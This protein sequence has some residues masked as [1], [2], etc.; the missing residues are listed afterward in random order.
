[1]KRIILTT[2]LAL[3]VSACSISPK[4]LTTGSVKSFADD[5]LAR[6]TAQQEPIT[7]GITIHEA[8]ARALKYNLDFHVEIFNESLAARKLETARLDTLPKL[9]TSAL[10][11][12][13]DNNSGNKN[14]ILF[15]DREKFQED[16]SLSWNILDFGLS[17]VRAQQAAD[18]V[19]VA[20]ENRR[21]IINRVIED[22][23]TAY[24]R[25]VSADRLVKGLRALEGRA[26][27]ALKNSE[28]LQL[29]GEASPLTALTYQRELVE[30][31]QRIQ[32]LQKDLSLAK[33]QLAALMNI[34]P[35]EHFQLAAP[36]SGVH[37][38]SLDM[39]GE[40]MVFA[41]LE[42]RPEIRDIQYKLRINAK[43]SKR[44]LLE[45]L[46]GVNLFASA[47]WDSDSYLYNSNWVGWGARATWNVMQV[48]KYPAQKRLI[49]AEEEVLDARALA[50][51]MAIITQVH[52]SRVRYGHS[53]KL[54][55]TARKH[56]KV[57]KGIL[58][59]IRISNDEGQASEQ[60]LIREEMNTLASQVAADIA[61]A[62]LQNAYANIFASMGLDPYPGKFD[63]NQSVDS[64]ASSL[65][66][67]WI[68]RGDKSGITSAMA[69]AKR[70]RAQQGHVHAV[71]NKTSTYNKDPFVKET[72]DWGDLRTGSVTRKKGNFLRDVMGLGK[73]NTSKT[74]QI[75]N[76]DR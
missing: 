52:V 18:Q 65:K 25:A 51:T 17:Y 16:I 45:L 61:Y 41:A 11:S 69:S 35:G 76:N 3:T 27:R 13:R 28:K 1:M 9:A 75:I 53:H 36:K 24:W 71:T 38:N 14:S 63:T 50:V 22:V 56:L 33:L 48:F 15:P 58:K 37:D 43:E 44:A 64:L 57:Q 60:T 29:D 12:G 10:Y 59:Q 8:M 26:K 73:P 67:M 40:E 5:K 55:H 4:P 54:Y 42:N 20:E 30:I 47:N 62:D 39:D 23:R 72:K 70:F 34:R 19:L 66:G 7:K 31:Q 2:A 32:R 49:A 68:E 46:P 21:K 74:P 6:V